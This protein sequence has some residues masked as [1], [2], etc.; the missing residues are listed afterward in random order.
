MNPIQY[1]I[2][3]YLSQ[4]TRK[5]SLAIASNCARHQSLRRT[6]NDISRLSKL[7]YIKMSRMGNDFGYEITELGREQIK[8]NKQ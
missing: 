5:K 8:E 7:G 4:T 2:L 1:Q 6:I 3:V